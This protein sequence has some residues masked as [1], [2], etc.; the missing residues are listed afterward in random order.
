MPKHTAAPAFS[1]GHLSSQ[2]LTPEHHALTERIIVEVKG[3]PVPVPEQ[4]HQV[5]RFL[6]MSG[7]PLGLL[8]HLHVPRLKDGLR[9]FV[10]SRGLVKS[11][12]Q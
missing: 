7:R 12:V 2:S 1:P 4:E 5:Q 11:G 9:R 10:N 8:R 6:R 3:V